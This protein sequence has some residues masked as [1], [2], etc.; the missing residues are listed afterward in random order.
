MSWFFLA[1]Y[2]ISIYTKYSPDLMSTSGNCSDARDLNAF[3]P[4]DWYLII[5]EQIY[6][7]CMVF[8]TNRP[9]YHHKCLFH[10]AN[11]IATC[12]AHHFCVVPR[13]QIHDLIVFLVSEVKLLWI[14]RHFY[15]RDKTVSLRR[16]PLVYRLT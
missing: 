15:F 11:P 2:S 13:R 8:S 9:I 10:G 7:E 14:V 6:P 5:L 4:F 16:F 3:F 12:I 1:I